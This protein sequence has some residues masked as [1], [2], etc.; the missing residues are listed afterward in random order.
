[1]RIHRVGFEVDDLF[2]EELFYRLALRFSPRYR[3]QGP[4]S[5]A[6]RIAVLER[7]GVVLELSQRPRGPGAGSAPR[8]CARSYLG[9]EEEDLEA[10]HERLSA[11]AFPGVCIER[12]RDRGDGIREL[13]LRDPEGNSIRLSARTGPEPRLAIRAVIFDVDGTLIDSEENYYLADQRLLADFGIPFTREDKRPYIGG[14][15]LDMMVDLKRR[16]GL[17]PSP[18]QLA[19]HKNAYYLELALAKTHVFPEMRRLLEALRAK[20]IPVAVASGSSP[21]VLEHV[22][23]AAGL[24]RELAVVVSAEEVPRGKPAPD[25]FEEAARRLGV[26]ASECAVLEDSEPGVEAA[27][28]AFMACIAVPYLQGAPLGRRFAMADVLFEGGM[29]EFRAEAALRFIEGEKRG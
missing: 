2:S 23:G 29:A 19:D 13:A 10:A 8:P 27:K 4:S 16:F 12:P 21:R 24:D 25:V 7:N 17:E 9:L 28:R 3:F 22:L 5:T 6:E 20:G 1:M 14:G 18:A 11:L 26:P 15:N